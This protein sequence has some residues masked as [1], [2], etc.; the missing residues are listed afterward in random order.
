MPLLKRNLNGFRFL[1][2]KKE[3]IMGTE[4]RHIDKTKGEMV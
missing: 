4:V 1:L 2:P 3:V